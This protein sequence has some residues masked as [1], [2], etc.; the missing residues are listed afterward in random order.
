MEI[1]LLILRVVVGLTLAAHGA[2]KLF[3]WFGGPGL[4]KTAAVMEQLRFVPGGRSAFMAGLTETGGGLLL[5]LGLATPAAAAL[6]F[7][8]MVVAGVSA[9]LKQ[10]FFLQ[11][12]GYEY[13]L[14]LGLAGLS[15]A[16]TGAGPLSLD[17]LLGLSLGGARWGL[18]AFAVGL[19]GAAVQL[20]GRQRPS[21]PV[22]TAGK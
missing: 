9:H 14:T 4:K 22:E 17:A 19:A 3:G 21:A 15:A 6:V 16:F 12:R 5:A 2:Q 13:N 7:A 1:G 10:G 8:V 20:A 18:A 11:N